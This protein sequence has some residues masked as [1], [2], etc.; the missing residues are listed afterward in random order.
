MSPT[1]NRPSAPSRGPDSTLSERLA[2]ALG[3]YH[4]SKGSLARLCGVSPSTVTNWYAGKVTTIDTPGFFKLAAACAVRPEWLAMGVG[5]MDVVAARSAPVPPRRTAT[6][7][8]MQNALGA[9]FAG[10]GADQP[11]AL[12]ESEL[13]LLDDWA[14]LPPSVAGPLRQLVGELAAGVRAGESRRGKRG[15]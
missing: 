1:T 13:A 6:G 7:P 8:V 9:L 5:P 15:S 10:G 4:G 11:R 12:A 14:A 3:R 2:L